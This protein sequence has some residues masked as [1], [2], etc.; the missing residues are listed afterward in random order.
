MGLF[1]LRAVVHVVMLRVV[2]C[3]RI[4]LTETN[5]AC[6]PQDYSLPQK[7]T[8]LMSMLPTAGMRMKRKQKPRMEVFVFKRAGKGKNFLL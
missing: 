6:T 7:P 1:D 4:V 3:F 2:R 8:H 5:K